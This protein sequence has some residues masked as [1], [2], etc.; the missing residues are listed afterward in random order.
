MPIRTGIGSTLKMSSCVPLAPHVMI[1][2]MS[3]LLEPIHIPEGL[4]RKSDNFMLT[5]LTFQIT[6]ATDLDT[7]AERDYI[8]D[9][10]RRRQVI[11]DVTLHQAGEHLPTE[12]VNRYIT[13]GEVAFAALLL[14]A[15]PA[16]SLD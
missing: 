1:L 10:L 13:D 9:E 11:G 15:E 14:E 4:P 2:L 3:A 16:G 7:N 6:H 5:R 12:H 8:V